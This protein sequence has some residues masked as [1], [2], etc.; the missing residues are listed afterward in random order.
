[1]TMKKSFVILC[2][3][4]GIFSFAFTNGHAQIISNS[5]TLTIEC[6]KNYDIAVLQLQLIVDSTNSL[7]TYRNEKMVNDGKRQITLNVSSD[8]EGY[9][10]ILK[11][12]MYL[13]KI[14]NS[15]I[16]TSEKNIDTLTVVS[17]LNL[18]Y[19]KKDKIL[20][21]LDT[22]K[23]TNREYNNFLNQETQVETQI[24]SLIKQLKEMKDQFKRPNNFSINILEFVETNYVNSSRNFKSNSM[25]GGGYCLYDINN[26]RKDISNKSFQGPF[27]RY[28][29]SLYR[30]HLEIGLLKGSEF[31]DTVNTSSINKLLNIQFGQIFYPRYFGRGNLR[32]FNVFAG[33]DVGLVFANS[34]DRMNTFFQIAPNLGCEIFKCKYFFVD[35]KAGYK[36]SFYKLQFLSG[37]FLNGSFDFVF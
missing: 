35:L 30:M 29:S 36:V 20:K 7:I 22:M 15:N 1:M 11:K 26:S 5:A 19:E 3:A 10:A 16:I 24:L 14:I 4:S 25:L 31:N 33:Y 34:K 23:I 12:L 8:R 18:S 9:S 17:N 27:I 28:S 6:R 37:P 21:I 32:Y 2:I 13:G